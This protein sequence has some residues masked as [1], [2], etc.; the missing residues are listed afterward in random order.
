MVLNVHRKY[1]INYIIIFDISFITG[2]VAYASTNKTKIVRIETELFSVFTPGGPASS[3]RACFDAVL[4][5][6]S[7]QYPNLS[8]GADSV[9]GQLRGD[10]ECPFSGVIN[11]GRVW[12][13]VPENDTHSVPQDNSLSETPLPAPLR[14]PSHRFLGAECH[15]SVILEG[16]SKAIYGNSFSVSLLCFT[17]VYINLRTNV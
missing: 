2:H 13:K 4:L 17:W 15:C 3:L 6:Q 10:K 11:S 8:E 12:R 9:G 5:P 7:Y 14:R 1:N 16:H